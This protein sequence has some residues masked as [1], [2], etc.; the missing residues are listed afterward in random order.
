MT[1]NGAGGE[2]A[3]GEPPRPVT[4][5]RPVSRLVRVTD[6]VAGLL[7]AGTLVA[8][9]VL[10]AARFAAPAIWAAP[11]IEAAQGPSWPRVIVHL[12]AGAAGEVVAA[13]RGRRSRGPR[14][15][16]NLLVTVACL[17]ALWWSWW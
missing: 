8:G 16:A 6:V 10:L 13:L 11:V 2:A 12:V 5:G 7:S 15:A 9:L 1:H 14:I 17:G 3:R 4:G